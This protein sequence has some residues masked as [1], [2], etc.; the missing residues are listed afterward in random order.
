MYRHVERCKEIRSESS[1][2]KILNK[3]YNSDIMPTYRLVSWGANSHGQLGQG[4]LSEQF[5]LPQE[6]DLSGC[7]L[8]PEAIR[9]IVG[10]AGHTLVLDVDGRVYSCGLN[11]KGQAGITGIEKE[12]ILTFQRIRALEH[13]I[14]IDVCC[15]WDSSLALTRNGEL[16]VWGSNRYGQLSLDPSVF[17]SISHPHKILIGE[18]IKNVSMGLRHTA[19]VMENRELYVCG[20]NNRG[21]LGL[22]NPETM[23]PYPLLD[24][25]TKVAEWTMQENVENVACGQYHT[26]V[27]TKRQTYNTYV[28]GDNKHGQLGF[29]PKTFSETRILQPVCIPLSGIQ[30]DVQIQIHAGWSHINIL[31]NGTVFSWGRNDYGQLGRSS[32]KPQNG[33]STEERLQCVEHVPKIVQLSVGSEHN[34]ALTDDGV[35]LCWGW[36]EHGNC[37]NGKTE[38]VLRPEVLPIS[39]DSIAVLVGAGAGHSFAVIKD[40]S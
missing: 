33:I 9:K 31:S 18:K 28:F 10:G 27:I 14:V 26:V 5:V 32:S 34:V 7:S 36:N 11:N 29:F 15:G 8:K 38:N 35:V 20:S 1:R 13:E 22:I 24:A 40:T 17:L 2:T 16:Y 6:V 23:Q 4:L 19:I 37:G 25:F 30:H 39:S 21:Q 12:N 3:E